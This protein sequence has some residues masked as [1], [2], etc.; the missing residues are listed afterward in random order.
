MGTA[1][2]DSLSAS[3]TDQA[4]RPRNVGL[5]AYPFGR[6]VSKRTHM[7]FRV[8]RTFWQSIRAVH[9]TAE[10]CQ[11]IPFIISVGCSKYI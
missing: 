3:E 11:Y 10:K 6:K 1:Y 9:K 4:S 8:P 5:K 7:G 2:L